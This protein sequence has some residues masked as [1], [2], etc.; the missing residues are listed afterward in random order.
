[1]DGLTT[2]AKRRFH[3]RAGTARATVDGTLTVLEAWPG[4]G[5]TMEP[6]RTAINRALAQAR[7]ALSA[8]LVE[9]VDLPASVRDLLE[10]AAH[11]ETTIRETVTHEV[12]RHGVTVGVDGALGTLAKLTVADV[13]SRS[14]IPDVV[15]YALC[16]AE[17]HRNGSVPV[18]HLFDEAWHNITFYLDDVDA[19]LDT[20]FSELQRDD[21]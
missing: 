6:V 17:E 13:E 12:M 11:P 9:N 3:A 2:F 19:R 10:S 1:M 18:Q 21:Y 14:W 8:H 5:R 20:L 7:A 15:N 16:E 4:A